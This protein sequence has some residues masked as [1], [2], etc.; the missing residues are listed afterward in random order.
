MWELGKP[1]RRRLPGRPKCKWPNQVIPDITYMETDE[2]DGWDWG[3]LLVWP[4][5]GWGTSDYGIDCLISNWSL[6]MVYQVF[7]LAN[8]SIYYLNNNITDTNCICNTMKQVHI[9][10]YITTIIQ[11]HRLKAYYFYVSRIIMTI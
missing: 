3:H 11:I 4:N 1:E 10:H 2:W 7:R 8:V 5:P 6:L 9:Q